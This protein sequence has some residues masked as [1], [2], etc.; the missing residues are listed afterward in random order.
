MV[1]ADR[2]SQI[3]AKV[4]DPDDDRIDS[5]R[6]TLAAVLISA[7]QDAEALGLLETARAHSVH[8]LGEASP[9]IATIDSNLSTIYNARGEHDR[10]LAALR[11]ALAIDE[12]LVGADALDVANVHYN[13]AATYRYKKDYAAA[14]TSAERA[15]AILA[16][17]SLGS[18]RHRIALTMAAGCANELH[19]FAGA[20][21][22]TATALGFP[23][24]AESPETTAWAQ[25]E[26]ARA[27]IGAKRGAEAR[28][29]LTA[30]R[31]AYGNLDMTQRVHQID[32]L[33]RQAH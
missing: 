18:D 29:L 8:Q 23:K 7:D 22:L 6:I 12:K 26:R 20:L 25:L 13:L 31:T 4:P 27:L 33:L 16:A 2:A 17:K 19:D 32:D 21:E 28:P 10:A 3:I 15:I 9:I 1:A 30:A 24:P 11:S 14:R 5:I